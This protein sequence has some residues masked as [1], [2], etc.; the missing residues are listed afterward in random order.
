MPTTSSL[1]E[2]GPKLGTGP[3][4]QSGWAAWFATR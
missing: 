3:L 4:N 2:A 1:A